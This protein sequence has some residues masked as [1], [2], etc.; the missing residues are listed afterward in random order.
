MAAGRLAVGIHY[1]RS[2]KDAEDLAAAIKAEGGQ[3]VA[4][5]AD[6]G[7][8]NEVKALI[9]LCSEAIGAP[10]CLINNASEFQ[11]DTLAS[12]T[13][14]SWH[15]HLDINL[16][17]P[18]FL[19]Q[20]LAEALP[21]GVDGNVI[22]IIDQRVWKPIAGLLLLH[23]LQGRPVGRHADAGAGTGPPH[24]RQ[25]HRARARSCRAS[26][27]PTPTSPRRSKAPCSAAGRAPTRSPPP[28]ASSWRRPR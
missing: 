7:N 24:S 26:T 19:A 18:V 6:L 21:A 1:R 12:T 22:N 15:L 27:R 3:A 11:P 14:Q 2:R 17:A 8:L 10:C 16:K 28:S 25:R 23:G 4:L 5:P 13:P 20:A 9:P